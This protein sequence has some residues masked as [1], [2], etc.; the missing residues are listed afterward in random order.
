M[1]TLTS[2]QHT[3]A[4][5][6]GSFLFVHLAAPSVAV[7]AR[8]GESLELAT[9]TMVRVKKRTMSR[10]VT[11]SQDTPL[12]DPRTCLLSELPDGANRSL[13]VRLCS[14]PLVTSEEGTAS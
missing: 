5:V 7:V 2:V 12:I 6:F 4:L 10:S 11:D 13:C 9:K 14:R 1:S 3:S 8:S